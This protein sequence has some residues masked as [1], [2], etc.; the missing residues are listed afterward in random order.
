MF[1]KKGVLRHTDVVKPKRQQQDALMDDL[2]GWGHQHA[3]DAR[4]KALAEKIV[5]QGFAAVRPQLT[6][7]VQAFL[8]QPISSTALYRFEPALLMLV[9]E[10]GR[11]ILQ[12]AVQALEPVDS[13]AL[14]KELYFQCGGY[15]R[16]AQRTPNR[17]L[18][19][20]FGNITLWRTGYRS[21]QR[22]EETIFP[23]EL[24]L[25]LVE[26]VSPGMLDWIG[27]TLA[28]AGMSQ[29]ATL[30]EI[31]Q[32]TGVSMGVKRLRACTEALAAALE[33]LRQTHQVDALLEMQ[34]IAGESSG[35][36]KPVL[37]VGRDGITL[38]NRQGGFEVATTATL[39]MYDRAGKRLGTIYLAHP[40]QRGQA[41]MDAMLTGLLEALFSRLDGPLPRLAYVTDSGSKETEYYRRVLRPM[42]HPVTG[43]KL[44][45]TRV[46][47]F[48]HA[49]ERVWTLADALFTKSQQR[50][51]AA[52][53]RRMLKNL[54][55]P[56][57]VGRVLHSAAALLS[58]RQLGK[59]R[60]EK[61]RK[62]YR[63]LQSRT[64]YMKYHEYQRVHLP[65]GS[66][67][68]EAACKTVFAQRLKLSGMRWS[69]EGAARILTLRTI[70]LSG[71]WA[72][73]YGASLTANLPSIRPYASNAPKHG[74]LAA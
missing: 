42:K 64:G 23:L 10:I 41:T 65:I 16:R 22:G 26:N 67:V 12:A 1:P 19:T 73:T 57:G 38:R 55:R 5:E 20:R 28:T 61:F 71:T 58:R 17:S 30:A 74:Q 7:A 21:W 25:G 15:R 43:A 8:A 37:C 9:R 11:L 56:S 6:A 36:R 39:S 54:K 63:Y 3:T 48:Y 44:D 33:P 27:Q 35:S 40:P 49:S 34:R 46:A 70:L 14:P 51:S 68:T 31:E 72:A 32:A 18:A 13:L 47:D 50:E 29:Q 45:W 60:L 59:A 24:M 66:G 4:R 52:W 69:S 53:A 62:A 2:N